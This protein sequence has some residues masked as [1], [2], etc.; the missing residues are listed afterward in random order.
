MTIKEFIISRLQ[1]F[2]FLVTLILIASAVIGGVIAPEQELHYYHLFSPVI[3]AGLCVLPTFVTYFGKEP[4]LRQY[5]LRQVIELVLV[6]GVV[7]FLISPPS[8]FEGNAAGFYL[9]LGAV[10]FVI[11]V[12]AELMMWYGKYRQSNKLTSQ[13]KKLQESE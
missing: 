9:M 4:C 12:L 10:I 8:S 1:L 11:Y 2:F 13:L 6:E 7:M 3:I 5:V